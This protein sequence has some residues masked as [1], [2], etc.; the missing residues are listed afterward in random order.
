MNSG[1][2]NSGDW[3]SGDWNSGHTNSG[4]R[5]SGDW[6]SGDRNSG[7]FNSCDSSNGVFCNQEDRNIRI[8][9]IPSGM[10][11]NKFINSVYYAAI[12]SSAFR[13]MEWVEYTD[14]EKKKDKKKALAGGYLKTYTY[15]K[16][17]ANWWK[18]MT[19]HNRKIIKS[20]PNFDADVFEDI[21]G[22]KI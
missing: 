3:N 4:Y 13:L 9:N 15:K 7:I 19:K 2:R 21:T 20:M 6:N 8:F 1:D 22:I 10:S 5:N 18:G 12:G 11:Y 17:C 16:A 14:D